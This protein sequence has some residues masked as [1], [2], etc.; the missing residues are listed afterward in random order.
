MKRLPMVIAISFLTA[1]WLWFSPAAAA[2]PRIGLNPDTGPPTSKVTVKGKGFF[3]N[4][5]VDIFFDTVNQALVTTTPRGDFSVTIE[6]PAAAQPGEHWITA[7]ERLGRIGPR[8][9]QKPFLVRTDWAQWGFGSER[10]GWNPYEN[11]LNSSNV[12]NLELAWRDQI[13]GE[14]F[15]SLATPVVAGGVVYSYNSY[16]ILTAF[17]AKTGQRLWDSPLGTNWTLGISPA[18]AGSLVYVGADDYYYA[19]NAASGNIQWKAE[20]HRGD[21]DS[22]PA[23]AD[24][25]VYASVSYADLL[26]AFK[27][28]DGSIIWTRNIDNPKN[29][30]WCN[31]PPAVAGGVVYVA[32]CSD[33]LYAFK[34]AKGRRQ[35]LTKI[36]HGGRPSVATANGMVY[37][38]SEGAWG[39]AFSA[40]NAD[41]GILAW[42][43]LVSGNAGP[44]AVANG[45]VYVG[46]G[47]GNLYAFNADSGA[48]LWTSPTGGSIFSPPSVANGVVYIGSSDGKIYAF[49]ADNGTLLWRAALSKPGHPIYCSPIVADGMVFVSDCVSLSAFSLFGRQDHPEVPRPDP[50]TLMPDRSLTLRPGQ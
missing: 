4:A 5:E 23:V 3:P 30:G 9:A 48:L 37:V 26:Y 7:K 35:W 38:G 32:S 18:V 14:P 8:A 16:G 50:G 27:G 41:S 33:H 10:Q 19:L 47:D 6:A 2:A 43:A 39:C 12:A 45:T 44:P 28:T 15:E 1:I 34:T 40:F 20:Y 13:R 11:T 29:S 21:I 42:S 36:F 24:G 46:S 31:G 49:R 25:V 17:K 22:S